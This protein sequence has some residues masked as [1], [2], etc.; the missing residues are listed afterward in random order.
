LFITDIDIRNG[1][2]DRLHAAKIDFEAREWLGATTFASVALEAIL[3]WQVKQMCIHTGKKSP[4][5]MKLGELINLAN[6]EKLISEGA[7]KQSRLA[8]DAR[9]LIHP[10]KVARSGVSS[11]KASALTALAAAYRVAEE[12]NRANTVIQ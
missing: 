12:L 4:D 10:G 7:A 2:E 1:I 5:E 9:N 11:S 3:L 8:Q 6:D